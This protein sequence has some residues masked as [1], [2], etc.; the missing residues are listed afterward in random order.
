MRAL[1]KNKIPYWYALYE[2]TEK[3]LDE[4]GRYTG[5]Q[6]VKYSSPVK[7]YGNISAAKGDAFAAQ[8]GTFADYDNVLCVEDTPIDENSV[9]WVGIEPPNPYNYRARRISRSLNSVSVAIKKVDVD[10]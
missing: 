5:E 8:F 10:E 9:L 1:A 7:A 4:S 3:L 6:N 2:G